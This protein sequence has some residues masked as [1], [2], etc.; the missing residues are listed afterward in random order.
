[1]LKQPDSYRVQD[2]GEFE[3]KM[4]KQVQHDVGF[5]SKDAETSSA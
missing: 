3:V 2:G 1:M 4:L 5:E